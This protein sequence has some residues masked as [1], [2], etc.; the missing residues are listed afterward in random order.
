M[1]EKLAKYIPYISIGVI[2]L[3]FG[4]LALPGQFFKYFTQS[5]SGYEVIFFTPDYLTSNANGRVSAGGIIAM[6]LIA[7]AIPSYLF[8]KKS[9]ASSLLAGILT[10]LG[11]IMFLLMPLWMAIIYRGN[12]DNPLKW[13]TYV[14]GSLLLVVGALSIFFA[15]IRLKE[16]KAA[17]LKKNYSYIKNK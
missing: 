12:P 10:T 16:E 17:P 1:K 13:V 15:V 7:L 11:G 9:S 2:V 5:Y 8:W 3:A 4:F 6:V 14:I